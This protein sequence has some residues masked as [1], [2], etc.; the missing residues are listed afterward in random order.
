MHSGKRN[1]PVKVYTIK[2]WSGFRRSDIFK[3]YIVIN[4]HGFPISVLVQTMSVELYS[5]KHISSKDS[6]YQTIDVD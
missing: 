4:F 6:K 3:E 2:Y 1:M 5:T